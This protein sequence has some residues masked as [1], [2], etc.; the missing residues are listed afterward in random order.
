MHYSRAL[1]PPLR[2][3]NVEACPADFF[4]EMVGVGDRRV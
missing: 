3:S 2:S 4:S 1:L